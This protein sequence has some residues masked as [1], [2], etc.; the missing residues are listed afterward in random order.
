MKR[1][2]LF[3]FYFGAE[4][5]DG[6]LNNLIEKY[7]LNSADCARSAEYCAEKIIRIAEVKRQ[8]SGLWAYMDGVMNKLTGEER[9]ALRFFGTLRTGLG[10]Q[11]ESKIKLIKRASMKFTRK[12]RRLDG[13]KSAVE[14]AEGFYCLL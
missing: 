10:R 13:F 12:A 3:K 1:K 14:L 2:R 6:A 11:P 9:E 5:L 8:L 7:A 4:R